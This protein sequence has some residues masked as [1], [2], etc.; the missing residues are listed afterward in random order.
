LSQVGRIRY[1]LFLAIYIASNSN[2]VYDVYMERR[3]YPIFLIINGRKITKVVIDPHFELRH[4]DSINDDIILKL[5]RTLDG[6]EQLPS[7]IDD[8]GFEYYVK[9]KMDLDNKTYKLVWLLHED[10]IFIGIVNAYRRD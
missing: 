3:E 1:L 5:V 7:N 10:N 2:I 6:I 4:K 8:E 9:D